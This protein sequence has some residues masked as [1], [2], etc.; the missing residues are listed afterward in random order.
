MAFIW[1][2][3]GEVGTGVYHV[4]PALTCGQIGMYNG[5]AQTFIFRIE[6]H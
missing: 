4:P 1:F 5:V 3:A 2:A 6:A